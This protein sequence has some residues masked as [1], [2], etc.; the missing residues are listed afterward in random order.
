MVVQ[1]RFTKKLTRSEDCNDRFLALL[2]NDS[3]LDLALL[4]VKNRPAARGIDRIV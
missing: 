2:G 3:E 4:D 1:A